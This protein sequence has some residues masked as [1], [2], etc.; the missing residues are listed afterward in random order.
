MRLSENAHL[1]RYPHPSSLRRTPMYASFLGICPRFAWTPHPAGG[2]P[3]SEALHMDIFYQPL[4]SQFFDSPVRS[5][6]Y[7]DTLPPHCSDAVARG[8]IMALYPI[9]GMGGSLKRFSRFFPRIKSVSSWLSPT[10]DATSLT[11][12]IAPS[13]SP[14]R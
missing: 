2:S 9:Y 5:L 7:I 12:L 11:D 1:L 6:G 3:V 13:G 14:T 10:C 4:R 8:G